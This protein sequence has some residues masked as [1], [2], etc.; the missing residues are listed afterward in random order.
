MAEEKTLHE[1]LT[2]IADSLERI[3]DALEADRFVYPTGLHG[4]AHTIEMARKR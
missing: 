2:R 4:N 1:N 3:A